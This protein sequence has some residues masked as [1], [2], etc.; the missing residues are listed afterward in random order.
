MIWEAFVSGAVPV[1]VGA[2]NIR[3]RLPPHSFIN[4][5]DYNKWDDLAEY[6]EKVVADKKL[7][8]FHHKWRDDESIA[9]AFDTMYEFAQTDPTCRLCRWA[10]AKKYG[11]GWDHIKQEVRSIPK[12]PKDKFCTTAD[13]GLVSKPFSE[14]W[15]TKSG[16]AEKVHEENSE[17][18]SCSSLV[19]DGNIEVDSFEGIRKVSQHD[20]VTDFII[21]EYKNKN[22]DTE[23]VLRLKF[24]GV[25]NPDGACF[26]NTH[27]L[28]P[29]TRGAKV[30]SASIQDNLVKVTIIADWE[31]SV[32]STGE[33][34]MEIV[35]QKENDQTL[36]DEPSKRVRIIIEEMS[37]IHDKMTE[38]L[39][40]S[41]SKLMIKDFVDPVDIFFVDS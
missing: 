3:D 15:V 10:Y 18:E 27:T 26:Y 35:I 34:I 39:P 37:P 14:H 2:D 7:W 29:T 9:T 30:S 1:V 19:A 23:V 5:N 31:T 33:G 25:R 38:Y 28:V 17:G 11:L 40:S 21:T 22:L 24:P 6:V 12:T 32:R 13:H 4:A 8:E 16:E 36:E 41:F 20:G